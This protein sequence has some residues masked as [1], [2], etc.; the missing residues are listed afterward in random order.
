MAKLKCLCG[1]ELSNT[2]Q[3]NDIEGTLLADYDIDNIESF[4]EDIIMGIDVW[5]RSVWECKECG[6]LAINHPKRDSNTVKWYKPENGEPG[7]LI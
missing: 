5:G 1:D 3:P 4:E 7:K 2:M 6:R